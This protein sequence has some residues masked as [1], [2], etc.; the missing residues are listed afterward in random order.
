MTD[1]AIVPVNGAQELVPDL[2]LSEAERARLVECEAQIENGLEALW[3]IKEEKLWREYGSFDSYMAVR[4]GTNARRGNQIVA[5]YKAILILTEQLE[6]TDVPLPTNENQ[7]RPLITMTVKNPQQAVGVYRAAVQ[8]AGG[9]APGHDTVM[10]ARRLELSPD[11][12]RREDAVSQIRAMQHYSA[13][14]EEARTGNFVVLL[15]LAAALESCEEYVRERLQKADVRDLALIRMLND[16]Y[17]SGRDTA[18]EVLLTGALQ[19]SDDEDGILLKNAR[20][21]DYRRLKEIA[22]KEHLA[23]R[24]AERL[25]GQPVS[26]VVFPDDLPGTIE[27][28]LEVLGYTTLTRLGALI[29]EM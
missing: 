14:A 20:S 17:K 5:A 16:D 27:S 18:K 15:G 19:F 2:Q 10:L 4:W 26:I 28:L 23:Q 29:G 21:Q 1:A 3:R 22:Y 9:T 25:Q 11:E 8:M 13:L 7:I 12:V 24:R 6:G